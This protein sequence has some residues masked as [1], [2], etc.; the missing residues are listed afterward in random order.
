MTGKTNMNTF[1]SKSLEKFIRKGLDKDLK[2]RYQNTQE[3]RKD[4]RSVH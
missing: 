3:M 4:F 1:E 2:N